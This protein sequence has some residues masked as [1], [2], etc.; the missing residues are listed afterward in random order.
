VRR[1]R[2]RRK[3]AEDASAGPLRCRPCGVLLLA[4]EYPQFAV[5]D[6][7]DLVVAVVDMHRAGVAAPGQVCRLARTPRRSA[8]RR[9]AWDRAPRNRMATWV[10]G[11]ETALRATGVISSVMAGASSGGAGPWLAAASGSSQP[12]QID[13]VHGQYW[14]I[15][16]QTLLTEP[17]LAGL[18]ADHR[19]ARHDRIALSELAAEPFVFFPRHRSV[20]A[21]DEFIASCRAA[22]FSPAIVQEASGLRPRIRGRR[23]GRDRSGRLLPGAIPGRRTVRPRRRAPARAPARLGGRQH[24]HRPPAFLET[25]RQIASQTD[26][27]LAAG[28]QAAEP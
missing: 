25:A 10:F 24:Q 15:Q 4:G 3:R 8:R 12:L 17:V 1:Q 5:E 23:P 18:P 6:E 14:Y 26:R 20:L 2:W 21:Y 11:L 27:T 28:L 13:N 19:L 7:E 9:G 22:G 16:L